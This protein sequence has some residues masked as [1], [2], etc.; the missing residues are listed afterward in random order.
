M[1][2]SIRPRPLDVP[3]TTKPSPA[4]PA[5]GSQ[6]AAAIT[7]LTMAASKLDAAVAALTPGKDGSA[8]FTWGD[9]KGTL[10]MF[11]DAEHGLQH[12]RDI[13][14]QT[15]TRHQAGHLFDA[16]DSDVANVWDARNVAFLV[17]EN[18]RVGRYVSPPTV[19]DAM[20]IDLTTA[21]GDARKAVTMLQGSFS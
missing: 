16:L 7:L 20:L 21:A 18:P 6:Q 5:P 17:G 8:P 15:F 12:G 14:T 1:L 11:E 10:E 3:P 9:D 2:S 13:F 19:T 4:T